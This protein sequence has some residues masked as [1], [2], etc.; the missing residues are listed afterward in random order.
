MSVADTSIFNNPSPSNGNPYVVTIE[1]DAGT[2]IV[3]V[4]GYPFFNAFSIHRGSE[5]TTPVA[6]PVGAKVEIRVTAGVLNDLQEKILPVA[7]T[8]NS[9]KRVDIF[10]GNNLGLAELR[11]CGSTNGMQSSGQIFVGQSVTYGG[12]IDYNGDNSPYTVGAGSDRFTLFRMWNNIKYWTA[13]NPANLNDWEFRGNVTA[14]ASDER[15]KENIKVIEDPL[16]KVKKLRGVTYDWKDNVEE[17]G[18]IP[19]EKSETGVIAQDVAAVIEDGVKPAPFDDDY[20]TVQHEKIIPL[21]IESI[22][23]LSAEVDRLKAKLEDKD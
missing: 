13:K 23:E 17:L 8:S 6:H 9:G 18:F 19:A 4:Y 22:K 3:T 16:E 11:V 15:L 12:G 1:S 10:T 14:Y 5:G 21:L 2:E 20:L 7:T